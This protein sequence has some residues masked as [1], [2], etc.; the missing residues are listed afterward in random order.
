MNNAT[1]L[2]TIDTLVAA[3]KAKDLETAFACYEPSATVVLQPN[4][5]GS[6]EEAIRTF[7][8]R[9]SE[10]ALSFEGHE[11]VETGDLALH[12]SRYTLHLGEKGN[13]TGR[14]ADVLR[15]GFDGKWRIAIDNAFA[16]NDR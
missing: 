16:G 6:G 2:G 4:Q 14:T 7:I 9:V 3:R 15:R 1:A 5:I 12:L 11:I 8:K 10:L 13:V